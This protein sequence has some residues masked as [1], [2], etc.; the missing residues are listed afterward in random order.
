MP[1]SP[2]GRPDGPELVIGL[3]GAVGT[4]LAFVTSAL[5]QS[6]AEVRY[7]ATTVSLSELL[8]KIQRWRNLA[9]PMAEDDR[10][11]RHMDA[12]DL[13][14]K[15]TK[16]GDALAVLATGA[17]RRERRALTGDPNT[18]APRTAYI[19]RSLKHPDEVTTLREIYGAS[20]AVVS[21]YAPR[22]KRIQE[23]A[24]KIAASRRSFRSGAQLSKAQALN[25]RD[26]AEVGE[27]FGQNV[28]QTFPK[29]DVFIDS[30]RPAG[31]QESV[32]R[33]IELYFG[34]PFHTPTRDEYGMFHG[35]AAALRSADLGRQ[36]GA[37][38]ASPRGDIVAIGTNEVPRAGGGLY[39][40]GDDPDHRDF[41]LGYD[42][43]DRM[44]RNLLAETLELLREAGW[45]AGRRTKRDIEKLVDDA[46]SARRSPLLKEAQ[47]MN[48][49]EFGRAVHAEM[50]ALVDA[51]RRGVSVAGSTLYTTTFPC[52][53][54]ARHIVA[55]G[56]QRVV[57][58][59]P[60][61]KSLAAEL[62][63]DSILVD[64]S[65]VEPG[66]Q[67]AFQPFVGVAPRRYLDLFTASDNRKG[68]DGK[69]S[70]WKKVDAVP[71]SSGDS[72]RYLARESSELAALHARMRD[73][74]LTLVR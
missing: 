4:D 5:T 55:G 54:C 32:K 28:R 35:Q 21:A 20:C 12:G 30:S 47:I 6:L 52:H 42:M 53:V 15:R 74:G 61:P 48:L 39:W 66:P 17:I 19:L 8:H 59:E 45:L 69:V 1:D 9:R 68:R 58:V 57:Y 11:N 18:A 23:L 64:P 3:V 62:Y 65:D 10:I 60:Y 13:V 7:R 43:N 44:K 26:E 46:V 31:V 40:T 37:V 73:V 29:A 50:A 67:V 16:R 56:I 2:A 25:E 22:D 33:F 34:Y 63:P 70:R 51:A 38:V 36:V 41:T 27:E 14:R 72:R 24:S 71:R 49:L